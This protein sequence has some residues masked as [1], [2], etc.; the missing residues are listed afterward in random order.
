MAQHVADVLEVPVACIR[1]VNPAE[2]EYQ[3]V[4]MRLKSMD[5]HSGLKA[6][7]VLEFAQGHP[8][9]GTEG[10]EALQ[11][12]GSELMYQLGRLCAMDVLMNNLDRIP[13]PVWQNEGN[14]GNVMVTKHGCSILGIDQQVNLIM[15]GP[16]LAMY[17]KKVVK[18]IADVSPNGDPS[19]IVEKLR[20]AL[21]ENCGAAITDEAAVI[22]LRGLH[23][24]LGH[25]AHQWRKGH[26]KQALEAGKKN[27][28]DR[29]AD[30]PDVNSRCL[31][32]HQQLDTL[33]SMC[34]FL[35]TVA[36]LISSELP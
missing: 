19:C 4:Q 27:S 23:L 3:E 13:I 9:M 21:M 34:N 22:F 11:N 36:E 15:P 26:L 17:M 8:L 1:V 6:F 31:L 7:G 24:G 25:I 18:L 16:G 5:A 12:H 20:Q 33:N 30:V 32:F 28:L 14:L 10:Q 2:D 35:C 29:F